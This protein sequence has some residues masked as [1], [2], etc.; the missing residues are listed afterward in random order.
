MSE[1]NVQAVRYRQLDNAE[2]V[3][4]T[5]SN[6]DAVAAWCQARRNASL[7]Q[8]FEHMLVP[9]ADGWADASPGDWV[10]RWRGKFGVFSPAQFDWAFTLAV[11]S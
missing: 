1:L 6:I 2:A 8:P 11:Q 10:V 9:V 4:I 3:Q 7:G 5:I